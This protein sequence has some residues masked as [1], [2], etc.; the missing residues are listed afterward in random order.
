[1]HFP[2]DKKGDYSV[3]ALDFMKSL[4]KE[5]TKKPVQELYS[6]SGNAAASNSSASSSSSPAG[7]GSKTSSDG[8]KS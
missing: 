2:I 7:N 6:R 1:M 8:A 5:G 4:K 3:V